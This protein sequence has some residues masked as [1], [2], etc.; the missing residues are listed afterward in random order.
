MGL[1]SSDEQ[2]NLSPPGLVPVSAWVSEQLPDSGEYLLGLL[3]FLS[4]E[5]YELAAAEIQRVRH[6]NGAITDHGMKD[7][8][9]RDWKSGPLTLLVGLRVKEWIITGVWASYGLG[10]RQRREV[11]TMVENLVHEQGVPAAATWAVASRP[12]GPDVSYLAEQ[13]SAAYD[14]GASHITNGDVIKAFRKWRR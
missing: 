9:L 7:I 1:F 4:P 14:E 5:S 3:G 8:R 10:R 6:A 11:T 2:I 13:L 12:N